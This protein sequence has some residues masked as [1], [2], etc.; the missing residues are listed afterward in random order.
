MFVR[1]GSALA[2]MLVL[3]ACTKSGQFDPT[4]IFNSDAFDSK[5]KLSGQRE[6]V[7]PN[8]VPGT[9]TGVPVDL[10]K[11]YQPPP[12]PTDANASQPPPGAGP[13][14]AGAAP[15]AH[16]GSE[17]QAETKTQAETRKRSRSTGAGHCA[18]GR[19]DA[20]D[21]RFKARGRYARPECRR[22]VQLAGAGAAGIFSGAGQLAGSASCTIGANQLAGAVRNRAGAEDGAAVAIDLAEPARHDA[23]G[24]ASLSRPLGHAAQRARLAAPSRLE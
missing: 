13:P 23:I 18:A 8:G 4:E 6:A 16:G 20:P 12:D 17:A 10:V 2:L 24:I 7:F 19:L 11:G 3:G 1:A 22:R 5:K 14:A 21:D 15:T 9:T